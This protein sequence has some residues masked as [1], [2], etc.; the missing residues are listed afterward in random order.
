MGE[1]CFV[2]RCDISP[3]AGDFQQVRTSG[4]LPALACL[5]VGGR[6]VGGLPISFFFAGGSFVF[7]PGGSFDSLASSIFCFGGVGCVLWR[8]SFN[9]RGRGKCSLKGVGGIARGVAERGERE[10]VARSLCVLGAATTHTHYF[11]FKKGD[12]FNRRGWSP[13]LRTPQEHPFFAHGG[14][15]NSTER[16]E[17]PPW[18]IPTS[19]GA[20]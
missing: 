5:H 2:S 20:F 12:G 14:D 19:G 18:R 17:T 3:Y 10:S 4:M 7:L 1:T 15:T 13:P 16:A 11:P 8:G 9:F 6:E